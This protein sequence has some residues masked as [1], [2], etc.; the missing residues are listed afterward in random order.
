MTIVIAC[1]GIC[2]VMTPLVIV[3]VTVETYPFAAIFVIT[4]RSRRWQ[5]FLVGAPVG[6]FQS[7][8]ER[9]NLEEKKFTVKKC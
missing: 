8:R 5:L 9:E 6:L 7:N 4:A 3:P 1:Q 2:G